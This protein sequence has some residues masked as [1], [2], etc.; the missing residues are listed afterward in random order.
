MRN[1]ILGFLVGAAT[2]YGALNL[3]IVRAQDGHH[4]LRKSTLAA[5]DT[6]VDIRPFGVNEWK[7]HLELADA[8][9]KAGKDDLVKG[10]AESAVR[11]TLE[12]LFHREETP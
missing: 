3:H 2:L 11:R 10:A 8:M 6:Y 9:R 4:V 12:G 1:F 7:D 5:R